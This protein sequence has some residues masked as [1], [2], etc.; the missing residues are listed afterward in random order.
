MPFD[1]E[2]SAVISEENNLMSHGSSFLVTPSGKAYVI[3]QRDS[4]QLIES[5][6]ILTIEMRVVSFPIDEWRN[7]DKYKRM[8][9]LKAGETVGDLTLSGHCPSDPVMQ[10]VGD[11]IACVMVAGENGRTGYVVRYLNTKDDSLSDHVERC[12]ISYNT[13]T[14]SKTVS[15]DN[16]GIAECYRDLGY[17]EA[18]Q[19]DMATMGKRFIEYEGYYYNV[20]SGWCCP[21]SRPIVIRTRDLVHYELAFDCPEF[22]YGSVEGAMEIFNGEFYIQARTS[23][24]WDKEVRGTYLGKYSSIGECLVQPYRIGEIESRPD[25]FIYDGKLYDMCNVSP[26]LVTEE[27]TIYRSHVRVAELDENANTVRG[28][29]ITSPNAIHY[30]CVNSYDGKMY[31]SFT[32]DVKHRKISQ[33]KGDIGFCEFSIPSG[34]DSPLVYSESRM[35]SE[36]VNLMT[37]CPAITVTKG[38]EALVM[39][40]R[41]SQQKVEDANQTTIEMKMV[42]FPIRKWK[43]ADPQ[44]QHYL[45]EGESIGDYIQE[46]RAPYDPCIF[47]TGN[48]VLTLFG[49]IEDKDVFY[50]ARSY[51]PARGEFGQSISAC[52][53]SYAVDGSTKTVKLSNEGVKEYYQDCRYA[54]SFVNFHQILLSP[55]YIEHQG[56]YYL[57]LS[58][59]CC[60]QFRPVVLK[61]RDFIN[62]EVAFICREFTYGGSEVSIT[63]FDNDL[64]V[65]SRS[66][67]PEDKSRA[68]CYMAK[69]SLD[70]K[71]LVEPWKIGDKESRP[72]LYASG[73]TL[74]AIY[75]VMP[76]YLD[77]GKKVNRS[78][79]RI[80]AIDKHANS[81]FGWDL[82][83]EDSFQYYELFRYKDRNYIVFIEDRQKVANGSRKGN[84]AIMELNL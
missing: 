17:G 4:S 63:I 82:T 29:D 53:L 36:P 59:W 39:Y 16:I 19:L 73:G 8:T 6:D 60:P 32:E 50:A 61:T 76:E 65:L 83:F 56:Y 22:T 84:L 21:Q 79:I 40:Y 18:E 41:D 66:T 24:V 72:V 44:W 78:H 57:A 75:N 15:L 14:G 27:G 38:G 71:C 74:Y 55:S 81:V 13:G 28:W 20:L 62:Y 25:L 33:C 77:N 10:L 43:D 42:R 23:R 49:G 2:E 5:G 30:Y 1:L 46:G 45:S 64:Y 51:N 3:Y 52:S 7:S 11:R 69:Y 37:H 34:D 35:I 48:T 47:N 80:S 58:V 67:R 31:M 26:N 12:D 9:I 54:D 68:G 70:G